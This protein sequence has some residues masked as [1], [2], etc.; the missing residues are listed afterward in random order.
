M[1]LQ[2]QEK[3]LWLELEQVKLHLYYL[4]YLQVL[5]KENT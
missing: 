1:V 3:L 4:I 2:D 5:F